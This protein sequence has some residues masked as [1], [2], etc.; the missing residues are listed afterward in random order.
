[1]TENVINLINNVGFPVAL[2]VV[3]LFILYRVGRWAGPL[4]HKVVENHIIFLDATKAHG[5]RTSEAMEKQTALLH[6]IKTTSSALIHL[7]N[8]GD[9]ALDG[10]TDS[11]HKQLD[12]MR[13]QLRECGGRGN[14][15]NWLPDGSPGRVVFGLVRGVARNRAF[16]PLRRHRKK[17]RRQLRQRAKAHTVYFL[18]NHR[19][20]HMV[21]ARLA[22]GK[23]GYAAP[24]PHA[25]R[26]R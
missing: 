11:A 6:E 13:D 2:V 5:K 1:M 24:A 17:R 20:R 22:N 25:R 14:L 15:L 12:K 19:P 26:G 21:R 9:D 16:A 3:L 10:R 23:A 4:A 7:A 18:V 8:A